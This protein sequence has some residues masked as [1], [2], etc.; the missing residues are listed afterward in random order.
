MHTRREEKKGE[1]LVTFHHNFHSRFVE[2]YAGDG[3][4]ICKVK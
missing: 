1:E 2:G 3:E 4:G